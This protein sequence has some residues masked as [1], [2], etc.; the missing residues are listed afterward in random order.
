MSLEIIIN[1][2]RWLGGLLAYTTLGILL[3]GIWRGTRRQAG[4]TTGS[5]GTWLRSPWFYLASSALFF[6]I[7]YFGWIP[8]PWHASLA[9][10]LWML[11]FGSL[12]YFPGMV[13][14]LCGRFALGKNYF[15]STAFGAQ[16]FAD[17]QLVTRG[18]FAIVRHPMYS[19]LIIAALGS[20][21]IYPTWT[22]LLFTCFAPLII[23]RA[24]REETALLMEFGMEWQIYCKRVP[25]F[26]PRLRRTINNS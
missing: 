10:R 13:F 26:I 4:R 18:L 11:A 5:T 22:T 17:H 21:L 2:I 16:L 25:G 3:Y 7:C 23:V 19:G 8:V 9:V 12:L 6:A 1:I 20:L 14:V 15:V 24:R